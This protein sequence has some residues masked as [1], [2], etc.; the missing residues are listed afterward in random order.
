[1]SGLESPSKPGCE[2][3]P[4][5]TETW[6][7]ETSV[8][9]RA[10][11]GNKSRGSVEHCRMAEFKPQHRAARRV[12]FQNPAEIHGKIGSTGCREGRKITILHTAVTEEAG[13]HFRENAEPPRVNSHLRAERPLKY[14]SAPLSVTHVGGR[15]KVIDN[16]VYGQPPIEVVRQTPAKPRVIPQETRG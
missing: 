9:G 3:H 12:V 5:V 16:R 13:T 2:L 15:V 14:F 10:R 6:V 4:V 1:M 11:R 7:Y 8:E